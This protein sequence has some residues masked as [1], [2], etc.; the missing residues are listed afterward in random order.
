M[1]FPALTA[2]ALLDLIALVCRLLK[3]R[4]GIQRPA[5]IFALLAMAA[6][7]GATL[8]RWSR[9]LHDAVYDI[10]NCHVKMAEYLDSHYPPGTKVGV[11]DIG[12]IAYFSHMDV[13]DLGGLVDRNYLPYLISGRVPQYLRQQGAQYVVLPI[14]SAEAMQDGGQANFGQI[15]HLLNNPA[16]RLEPI[17]SEGVDFNTWDNGNLYSQNAYE[18]QIL[19]RVVPL[20][21]DGTP[22]LPEGR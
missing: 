17:H 16:L 9:G 1:L 6:L 19:Y 11:F 13:L 21:P 12:A 15:L 7:T 10:D 18:Y 20:D 3:P 5:Q 14:N 4:R 22:A 8:P 2:I